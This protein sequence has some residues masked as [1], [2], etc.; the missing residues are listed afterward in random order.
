MNNID[1]DCNSIIVDQSKSSKSKVYCVI[2]YEKTQLDC[3]DQE[4]YK[5]KCPR[6]KNDYLL[7]GYGGDMVKEEDELVSSHETNE[8]GPILMTLED[9][10]DTRSILDRENNTKTDIKRPKYM[11]DSDTTKVIEYHE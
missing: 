1:N 2:C 6:C 3:I 7:F 4:N 9:N 10:K 5:W 11:L 8:E